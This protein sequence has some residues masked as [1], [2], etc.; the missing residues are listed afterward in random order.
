MVEVVSQT[1]VHEAPTS[2]LPHVVTF[3]PFGLGSGYSFFEEHLVDIVLLKPTLELTIG[4][5]PCD[6]A[7]NG[8]VQ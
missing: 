8:N 4:K 1:A 2:S 3:Y 6:P 7:R 5:L